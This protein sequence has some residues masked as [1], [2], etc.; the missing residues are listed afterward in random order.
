MLTR[1]RQQSII[2]TESKSKPMCTRKPYK[3]SYSEIFITIYS[4]RGAINQIPTNTSRYSTCC[5]ANVYIFVF[6]FNGTPLV[7]LS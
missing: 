7:L 6:I 5:A 4:A 1:L 3:Y 2:H